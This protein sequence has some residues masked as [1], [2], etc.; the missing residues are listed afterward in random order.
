MQLNAQPVGSTH[1]P[2]GIFGRVFVQW[3]IAFGSVRNQLGQILSVG[4]GV[5]LSVMESKR[6][7]LMGCKILVW[8]LLSDSFWCLIGSI[9]FYRQSVLTFT[10]SFRA[11][12]AI[13]ATFICFQGGA[14]GWLLAWLALGWGQGLWVGYTYSAVR[15]GELYFAAGAVSVFPTFVI[16]YM[17]AVLFKPHAPLPYGPVGDVVT[18]AV[19]RADYAHLL[20]DLSVALLY[21]YWIL[22]ETQEC[23]LNIGVSRFAR[24]KRALCLIGVPAIVIWGRNASYLNALYGALLGLVVGAGM[25]ALL[26]VAITPRLPDLEPITG[27]LNM[28]HDTTLLQL[29]YDRHHTAETRLSSPSLM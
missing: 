19:C 2:V 11:T 13:S 25:S 27:W 16:Q 5:G 15:D 28:K 10:F 22:V 3:H 26:L 29:L 21:H 20:P 9:Y 4:V 6:L 17:A 23:C 18:D 7:L 12:M 1:A 14:L 24:L 8:M